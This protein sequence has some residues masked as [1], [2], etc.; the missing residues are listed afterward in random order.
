MKSSELTPEKAQML[1]EMKF[2]FQSHASYS[3]GGERWEKCEYKGLKIYVCT[4]TRRNGEGWGK[5]KNT[6]FID[7]EKK[8][9]KDL[10]E[11]LDVVR[12]RTSMKIA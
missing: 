6:Y 3:T 11:F 5:G 9:Y 4:F 10:N 7:K 2:E 12:Q 8:E 1:S